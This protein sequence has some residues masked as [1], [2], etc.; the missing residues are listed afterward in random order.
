MTAMP[1]R[2]KWYNWSSYTTDFYFGPYVGAALL[3]AAIVFV[4]GM[5]YRLLVWVIF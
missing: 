2:S 5:L 4:V 1:K 3:L